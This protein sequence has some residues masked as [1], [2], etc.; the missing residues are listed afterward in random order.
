MDQP[1]VSRRSLRMLQ[2]IEPFLRFQQS[3]YY[4]HAGDPSVSD[5]VFGNP[6]EMP[7]PGM[8]EALARWSVPQNKDWFA[9]K[10]SEPM[11][12]AAVAA[13][14]RD[15]RELPYAAEDICLTTGAFAALSASLVAL[16]DSGDEV[17]FMTPPWFFYEAMVLAQEAIPVRVPVRADTFDL[18]LEAIAA[19]ITPRTRA[20]LVNSPNNPTGRIYPEE[21][22][23]QLGALLAEASAGRE[24]PI[25][26]LSDEA[27]SRLL[28]DGHSFISPVRFY[29]NS[30]LIYTYGKT[31]LTPG[32]RLGYIAITPGFAGAEAMR[33]ALLG[34][35]VLTGFTF[36]NA[37][38][39][40]ALPELEHL[41]IDVAHLQ[42]KRDRLVGALRAIGYQLHSPEGTFY[43]LP[44]SPWEDD[45]AFCTLLA[46]H[47]VFC[48]P[49]TIVELPGYFRISLTASDEMI[50]RSLPGFAAAWQEAQHEPALNGQRSHP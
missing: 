10:L 41:S 36:P 28:F 43:L 32:Q 40:Y 4:A 33:T 13:S 14:L 26:L 9:Y 8:P 11:P 24:R 23:R 39:Q 48:L 31:L 47:K 6:Q 27:Y 2:A 1:P 35:Q 21:T 5:F 20:V 45:E 7:L 18:D 22:L 30:L 38:M 19:A 44:R 50:E 17:I 3:S 49:G 29:A 42:L 16:V 12:R 37:L 25:V 15:L 34:A 46:R